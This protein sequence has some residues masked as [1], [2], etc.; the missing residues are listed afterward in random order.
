MIQK[1]GKSNYLEVHEWFKA[2]KGV[3]ILEDMLSPIGFIVPGVA[4][5][6]LVLTNVNCCFFEPFIANP[7]ASKPARDEA[8]V[9]ILRELQNKSK[10]LG[11]K[12]I[13]GVST[14]P[15]MIKRALNSGWLSLGLSTLVCKEN[16]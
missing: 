8:L 9:M 15:T 6:F 4:A 7:K 14:S 1:Y 12:M 10:E 13:Y 11:I 5:G 16:Q 2:Q 3:S